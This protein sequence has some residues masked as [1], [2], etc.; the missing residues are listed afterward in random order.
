MRVISGKYRG[1]KLQEFDLQTTKPTLDRVK[2]SMFNLIQFQISDAVV[3]DLFAGTGALGIECVSRGARYV[4]FVDSNP[5]AI[6]IV[7][8]NLKN[9]DRQYT[10]VNQDYLTFLK[11]CKEKF[12]IFLIDP[13]YKTE[14]GI[15]AIKYINNNN[16]LNEQGVILFETSKDMV[17][18]FSSL[19]NLD[20]DKRIYGSVAVYKLT[21]RVGN[22]SC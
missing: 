3:C 2:E 5:K 7:Q 4:C 9:M 18:D 14:L 12:D 17:F 15:Q 10:V 21:K 11:Q 1:K 13:P 20:M 22:E 19:Q 16:L 6:K 8:Q